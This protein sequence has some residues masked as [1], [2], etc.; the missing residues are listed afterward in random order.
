MDATRGLMEGQ[1]AGIDRAALVLMVTTILMWAGSWIVMKMVVPYIGPFDFVVLR[2]V[3]GGALLLAT[4]ALLRRRLGMPSWRLTWLVA[5]TQTS[6]FQGLV[7]SAL[8]H[9]GVGK[10]SLMA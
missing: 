4:A 9:G 2:Y 5:L 8:I 6:G 1:K 7:Q 3:S 10:I